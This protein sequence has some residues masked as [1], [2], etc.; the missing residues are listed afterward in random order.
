MTGTCGLVAMALLLLASGLWAQPVGPLD[1]PP[2]RGEKVYPPAPRIAERA[3]IDAA[4]Q[5][6]KAA[7]KELENIRQR[8]RRGVRPML[9]GFARR[10]PRPISVRLTRSTKTG[11]RLARGIVARSDRGVVWSALFKVEDAYQLRLHLQN[12]R[13]PARAVLWVYG[14][15][16][17][18]T[19]F[20]KELLDSD[21]QSLWTP[22]VK[23]DT[24]YFEL[25]MPQPRGR[26]GEASFVIREVMELFPFHKYVTRSYEDR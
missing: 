20:G 14:R 8:N 10:F 23:G 11:T 17:E 18:P 26:A 13:L 15:E 7:E 24:I 2:A 21:S 16:Q 25:E 12:V 3:A 19:G 6:P 9:N 4:V 1:R 22:S 5:L